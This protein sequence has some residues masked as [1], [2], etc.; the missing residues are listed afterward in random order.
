V[1]VLLTTIFIKIGTQICPCQLIKVIDNDHTESVLSKWLPTASYILR[2]SAQ[3]L[4]TIDWQGEIQTVHY[5]L[6][7][8]SSCDYQNSCWKCLLRA[9]QQAINLQLHWLIVHSPC[10][11]CFN[12]PNVEI[13]VRTVRYT[14]SWSYPSFFFLKPLF[15]H[16]QWRFFSDWPQN[17]K[18]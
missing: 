8:T 3:P 7:H 1:K 14:P 12:S 13:F 15:G 9:I 17:T 11:R 18:Q 10:S 2:W 5:F 4:R 16:A 6:E